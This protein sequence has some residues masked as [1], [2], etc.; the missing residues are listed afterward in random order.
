MPGQGT[1]TAGPIK[2]SN[3][4][5][6]AANAANASTNFY[7]SNPAGQTFVDTLAAAGG[8]IKNVPG[9]KTLGNVDEAI[10]L[11]TLIQQKNYAEIPA[12]LTSFAGSNLAAA[13]PGY[14]LT[15]APAYAAPLASATF[16]ASFEI[17]QHTV[18]PIVGP[19]LGNQLFNLDPKI[20]TPS[21]GPHITI[22]PTTSWTGVSTHQSTP[23]S[24]P[25][26]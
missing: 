3:G 18:A 4:A 10:S 9:L 14:L 22:I 26:P 20:W 6:N 12:N 25:T 19:W 24:P 17:G 16:V 5:A 1:L 2:P 23:L 7:Q 21:S 8:E 13:A 11:A 15:A